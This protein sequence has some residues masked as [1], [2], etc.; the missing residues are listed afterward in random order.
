[1]SQTNELI[2]DLEGYRDRLIGELKEKVRALL[3]VRKNLKML[4][5]VNVEMERLE[6]FHTESIERLE[7]SAKLNLQTENVNLDGVI[8]SK[9][10][11]L[12]DRRFP[13]LF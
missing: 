6:T 11:W 3:W 4:K 13:G 10:G 7:N 9:F 8:R 5:E 2:A 1:M 12:S